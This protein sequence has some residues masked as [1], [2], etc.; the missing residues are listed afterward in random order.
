[1]FLLPFH[2]VSGSHERNTPAAEHQSAP[3]DEVARRVTRLLLR[4]LSRV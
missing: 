1:V 4:E 3:V 2:V